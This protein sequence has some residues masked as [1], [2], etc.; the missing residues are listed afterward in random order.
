VS[1]YEQ[2][3]IYKYT[4]ANAKLV[5]AKTIKSIG[6]KAILRTMKVELYSGDQFYAGELQNHPL[7]F[8]QLAP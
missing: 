8:N 5:G 2:I 1:N 6:G 7:N 3:Y 4:M